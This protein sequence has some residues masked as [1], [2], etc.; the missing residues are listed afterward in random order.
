MIARIQSW[1]KQMD[2][3][4]VKFQ[5]EQLKKTRKRFWIWI[6]NGG[7]AI[8]PRTTSLMLVRERLRELES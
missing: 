8:A 2:V 3:Y 4:Q 6:V 5:E 7:M 1:L